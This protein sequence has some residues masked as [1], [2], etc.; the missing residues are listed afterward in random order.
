MIIMIGLN[1]G[2][3]DEDEGADDEDESED[4]VDEDDDDEDHV[5]VDEDDEEKG[6]DDVVDRPTQL[7]CISDITDKYKRHS[8]AIC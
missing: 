1:P 6:A 8:R 4:D 2:E 3:D 5:D 7:I